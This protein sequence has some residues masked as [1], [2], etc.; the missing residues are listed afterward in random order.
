[1]LEENSAKVIFSREN[2]ESGFYF[3]SILI[4]GIN[5]HREKVVL[6]K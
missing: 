1:M 3:F 2:L 5:V 6:L 4:N